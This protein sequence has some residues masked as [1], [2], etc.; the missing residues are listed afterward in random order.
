M[1]TKRFLSQIKE[2]CLV[3]RE[4][5]SLPLYALSLI[6]QTQNSGSSRNQVRFSRMNQNSPVPVSLSEIGPL[7][8]EQPDSHEV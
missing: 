6:F 5:D 2:S 4:K 3:A 1:L 7:S 8:K